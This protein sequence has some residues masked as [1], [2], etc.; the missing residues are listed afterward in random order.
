[1]SDKPKA[2]AFVTE[3]NPEGLCNFEDAHGVCDNAATTWQKD[4][5]GGRIGVCDEHREESHA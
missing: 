4:G 1:M 2:E 5:F 3:W